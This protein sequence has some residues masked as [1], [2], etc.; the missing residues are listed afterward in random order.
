MLLLPTLTDL[1]RFSDSNVPR[2]P[3]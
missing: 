1:Q 2:S 3:V